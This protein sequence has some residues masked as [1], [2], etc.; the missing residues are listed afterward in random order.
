MI[1]HMMEMM[2]V[3]LSVIWGGVVDRHQRLR[4]AFLEPSGARAVA[5]NSLLRA[6][7]WH[8]IGT[9][10]MGTD[11]ER[12]VIDAEGRCHDVPASTSSTA[13]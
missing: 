1:S 4:V 8:L 13:A 10:R 12:S 5:V 9:A 2:L 3:A 7:G 6:G 11:P